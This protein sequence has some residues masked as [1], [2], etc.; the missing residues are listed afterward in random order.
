MITVGDRDMNRC[1]ECG[2]DLPSTLTLCLHHLYR[3]PAW[4][5]TNRMMCDF[6]H[7]GRAPARLPWAEGEDRLRG[8]LAE[9]AA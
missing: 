5:K 6:L 8:C 4:A 1:S 2:V 9:I 3:D 7:R